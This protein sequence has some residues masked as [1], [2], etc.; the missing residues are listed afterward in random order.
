MDTCNVKIYLNETQYSRN[1]DYIGSYEAKLLCGRVGDIIT[2][3]KSKLYHLV[4]VTETAS[5][6]LMPLDTLSMPA[7]LAKHVLLFLQ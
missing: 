4:T 2:A 7:I 1:A 3:H 6:D 5:T